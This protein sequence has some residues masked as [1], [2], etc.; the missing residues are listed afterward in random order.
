MNENTFSLTKTL[1]C[2]IQTQDDISMTRS[3]S[4]MR[5]QSQS[6]VSRVCAH[7]ATVDDE[8]ISEMSYCINEVLFG[9]KLFSIIWL[10]KFQKV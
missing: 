1:I 2:A 5:L 7:V 3:S 10:L 9:G 4:P 8:F 6:I